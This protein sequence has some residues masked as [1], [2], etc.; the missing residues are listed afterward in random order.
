M[1][2]GLNYC[3]DSNTTK[4]DRHKNL[5]N[6]IVS[7]S[8]YK[9]HCLTN[10]LSLEDISFIRSVYDSLYKHKPF[11]NID[12][13]RYKYEILISYDNF[14]HD[15]LRYKFCD[16]NTTVFYSTPIYLM[17]STEALVYTELR[18]STGRVRQLLLFKYKSGRW[19]ERGTYLMQDINIKGQ[20][21][22]FE[23]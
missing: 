22:G 4:Y 3:S 18:I 5:I 8:F 12:S 21:P 14:L 17:D 16:N 19:K 11:L 1:V 9:T 2:I 20:V 10:E 13:A 23:Y 15:S 6:T 7:E